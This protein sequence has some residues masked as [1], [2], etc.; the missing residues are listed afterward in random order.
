[1]ITTAATREK[2]HGRSVDVVLGT[3]LCAMLGPQVFPGRALEG[4][5]WIGNR[6]RQQAPTILGQ[7]SK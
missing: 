6:F 7:P 3:P 2:K 5:P 1:M 4:P